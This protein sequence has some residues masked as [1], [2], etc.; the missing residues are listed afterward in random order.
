VACHGREQ[1]AAPNL[2]RLATEMALP[3]TSPSGNGGAAPGM[4]LSAAGKVTPV[5]DEFGL[6]D[7]SGQE[8]NRAHFRAHS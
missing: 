2:K 8:K 5:R 6:K 1:N 4:V 3:M 7:G